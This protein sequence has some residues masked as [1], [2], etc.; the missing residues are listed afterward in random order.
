MRHTALEAIAKGP[1]H[2]HADAAELASRALCGVAA[3]RDA[4][5]ERTHRAWRRARKIP[6][7]LSDSEVRDLLHPCGPLVVDVRPAEEYAAGHLQGAVSAP[8]DR[9]DDPCLGLPADRPLLLHCRGPACTFAA[10]AAARLRTLGYE[11]HWTDLTLHDL[12]SMLE[13]AA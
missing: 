8:V 7:A 5:V 1:N 12:R 9:L 11:A 2:R 4:T 10:E 3:R 6:P 13:M